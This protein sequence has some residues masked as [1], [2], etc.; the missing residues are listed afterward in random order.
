MLCLK[1][2]AKALKFFSSLSGGEQK[3]YL[4]WIY[5]SKKEETKTDY[6]AKS[7]NYVFKSR[8]V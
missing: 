3:Q 5:S 2:E 8:E 7:T 1:E 4:D 6:L